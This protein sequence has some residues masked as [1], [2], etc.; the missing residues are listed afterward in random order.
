[1]SIGRDGRVPAVAVK[2]PTDNYTK[3][4][5]IKSPA[6]GTLN[7]TSPPV[8]LLYAEFAPVVIYSEP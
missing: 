3:E 1:M 8:V 5:L 7:A 6:T 4:S 2:A